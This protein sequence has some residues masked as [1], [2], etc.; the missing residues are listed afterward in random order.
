MAKSY[1]VYAYNKDNPKDILCFYEK[2]NHDLVFSKDRCRVFTQQKLPK[3]LKKTN[4]IIEHDYNY[5]LK[6]KDVIHKRRNKRWL[7]QNYN[8]LDNWNYNC[9]AEYPNQYVWR[10]LKHMLACYAP[11][12]NYIGVVCRADSK[13]CPIKI[14]MNERIELRKHAKEYDKDNNTRAEFWDKFLNLTFEII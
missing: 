8:S 1:I 7:K 4:D 11:P 5:Y 2:S 3:N 14:N 10:W 9:Y 13:F 6:R 12:K